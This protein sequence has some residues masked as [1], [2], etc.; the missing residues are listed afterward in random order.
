MPRRLRC[1]KGI[2]SDCNTFREQHTSSLAARLLIFDVFLRTFNCSG[3][4]FSDFPFAKIGAFT[5]MPHITIKERK[6]YFRKILFIPKVYSSARKNSRHKLC[7]RYYANAM[8]KELTLTNLNHKS[9]LSK[10]KCHPDHLNCHVE[11]VF[12]VYRQVDDRRARFSI[13]VQ[14][15]NDTTK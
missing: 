3:F 7:H 6:K 14:D 1:K 5:T 15:R 9:G 12:P 2:K 4:I 11:P 13:R 8:V 10:K